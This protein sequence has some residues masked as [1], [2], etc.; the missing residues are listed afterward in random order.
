MSPTGCAARSGMLRIGTGS[1]RLRGA[2]ENV[3]GKNGPVEAGDLRRHVGKAEVTGATG[4]GRDRRAHDSAGV[5]GSGS[6]AG[7]G[8]RR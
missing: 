2:V 7:R 1:R 6:D 5:A 8:G 3:A 4:N